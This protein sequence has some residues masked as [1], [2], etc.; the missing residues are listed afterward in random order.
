[1]QNRVRRGGHAVPED[2]IVKRYH[3]SLGLLMDAIRNTNRAYIFDNSGEGKERTW[4]AEITEGKE[5]EI[6]ADQMPAW[7]KHAVWDKLIFPTA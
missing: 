6:R 2:K 7:F 1:V 5:L 3:L 4:L